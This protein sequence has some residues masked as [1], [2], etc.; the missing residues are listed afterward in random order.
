[1]IPESHG[2]GRDGDFSSREH[3]MRLVLLGAPGSGKGTQAE[4]IVSRLDI[5]HLSTGAML[6]AAVASNSTV[7]REVKAVMELG[8]LVSDDIVVR[9]VAQRLQKDDVKSGYVLDGFP[10]TV[11][12]AA[13]LDQ[14]LADRGER[15]DAVV[16]LKVVAADLLHRIVARAAQAVADGKKP[17]ADDN[18]ETFTMRLQAYEELTAP[19]V[20]YYRSKAVL[21]SVDGMQ[22]PEAVTTA[23]RE[24]IKA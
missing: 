18:P 22:P 4:M 16:E 20:D 19:L 21:K 15:L 23:I 14:V 9:I 1:M 8:D 3:N 13:A 17:R 7:G 10:R 11:A 12:Q 5:A 2:A 24:A 6:R